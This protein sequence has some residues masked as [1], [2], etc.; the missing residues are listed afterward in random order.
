MTADE[1][2]RIDHEQ[3]EAYEPPAL[4]VLGAAQALTL[5]PNGGHGSDFAFPHHGG[6]YTHQGSL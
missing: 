6:P 2:T 5:G 4:R 3:D 1:Q